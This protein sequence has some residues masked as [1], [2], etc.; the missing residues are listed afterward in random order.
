[1]N[2]ASRRVVLG[3]TLLALA[4]LPACRKSETPG[5][6]SRGSREP[7]DQPAGSFDPVGAAIWSLH[8]CDGDE[9]ARACER[10]YTAGR[11]AVPILL[12]HAEDQT[13]AVWS[14]P[15]F[16]YHDLLPTQ[17]IPV[18]EICLY[19][20]ESIR[21]GR[22]DHSYSY[23][24]RC[25]D[26]PAQPSSCAARE[27]H[28]WWDSLRSAYQQVYSPQVSWGTVS[29]DAR[30]H[31]RTI[32]GKDADPESLPVV[33]L[34]ESNP[35]VHEL[36]FVDS[37][38][39]YA[40]QTVRIRGVAGDCKGYAWLQAPFYTFAVTDG[41]RW[42]SDRIGTTIEV[43]AELVLQPAYAEPPSERGEEVQSDHSPGDYVPA[44]Y[45][46]RNVSE[47]RWRR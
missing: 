15:V 39:C 26:D 46:I 37:I 41:F 13:P 35:A 40:N 29:D 5:P 18:G 42:P 38:A 6:T 7:I 32:H 34:P 14:P 22:L 12:E 20:V 16:P 4:F 43:V 3:V 19:L 9:F 2:R 30:A 24:F 10:I 28:K 36:T 23:G 11:A 21:C 1:M 44:R 8:S 17:P 47:I 25:A 27:Y 33:R 31:F 45:G